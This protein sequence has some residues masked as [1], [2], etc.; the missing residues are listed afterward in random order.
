M[1]KYSSCT[2]VAALAANLTLRL[3]MRDLGKVLAGLHGR[4]V[5]GWGNAGSFLHVLHFHFLM[6]DPEVRRSQV[7]LTA[8]PLTGTVACSLSAPRMRDTQVRKSAGRFND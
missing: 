4:I 2:R 6:M 8:L 3:A 5:S 1:N 7:L